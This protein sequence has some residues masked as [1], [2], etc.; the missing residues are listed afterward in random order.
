METLCVSWLV[1]LLVKL[2]LLS[3]PSIPVVAGWQDLLTEQRSA[4]LSCVVGVHLSGRNQ[5]V[6]AIS[7]PLCKGVTSWV[8]L[9]HEL[10]TPPSWLLGCL[11]VWRNQSWAV[12]MTKALVSASWWTDGLLASLYHLTVQKCHQLAGDVLLP[13]QHNSFF[14]LPAAAT[15][16]PPWALDQTPGEPDVDTPLALLSLRFCLGDQAAPKGINKMT[17]MHIC[18]LK[19]WW[20]SR[21]FPQDTEEHRKDEFANN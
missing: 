4:P 2:A 7:D 9:W 20:S 16:L 8:G 3:C 12:V 13:H 21:A 18:R 10:A 17:L 15:A 11:R 14:L 19:C 5:Q 1:M 6:W